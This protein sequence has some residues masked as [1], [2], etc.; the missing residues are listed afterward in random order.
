MERAGEQERT[1]FSLADNWIGEVGRPAGHSGV[2][3]SRQPFDCGKQ[4]IGADRLGGNR[5]RL[6]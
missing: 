3:V 5:G 1:L 2:L 6:R 4:L